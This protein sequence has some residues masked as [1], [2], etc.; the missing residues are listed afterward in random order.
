[1]LAEL[2]P[3][4]L[5]VVDRA[6]VVVE[7]RLAPTSELG[8]HLALYD[9]YDCGAVVHTHAPAA[10][11]LSCV[12]DELPVIHYE[13]LLLGGATRVAPFAP[14][15]TAALAEAAAD[16]IDGRTAA[17][18]A[19]HG[20]ITLGGDLAGAMRATQLLEWASDLYARAAA[21]GTPRTLDAAQIQS[22]NDAAVARSYGQTQPLSDEAS[23]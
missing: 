18:L 16:A 23:R 21:L 2:R 10:T 1:V 15:G 12:L 6:G 14:F 9:R 5:A 3:D 8:L 17:L 11:A 7:G 4:D 19:Q 13:Q 20:T 22:V